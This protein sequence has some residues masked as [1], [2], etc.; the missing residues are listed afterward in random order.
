[1]EWARMRHRTWPLHSIHANNT[2]VWCRSESSL[3]TNI[4]NSHTESFTDYITF[5]AA[6]AVSAAVAAAVT[7]TIHRS[8]WERDRFTAANVVFLIW[9]RIRFI[10]CFFILFV[11]SVSPFHALAIFLTVSIAL[12]SQIRWMWVHSIRAHMS[13]SMCTCWFDCVCLFKGFR[14]L[15]VKY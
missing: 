11:R 2:D 8:D 12:H 13:M 9:K 15:Y 7:T 1:M 14:I 6:F 4:S 10:D 5:A 3:H